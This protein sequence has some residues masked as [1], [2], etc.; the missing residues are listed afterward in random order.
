MDTF[1]CCSLNMIMSYKL[2]AP[3]E[4]RMQAERDTPRPRHH[5]RPISKVINSEKSEFTDGT[6]L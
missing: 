3:R 5:N 6:R 1:I 4:A 2:H